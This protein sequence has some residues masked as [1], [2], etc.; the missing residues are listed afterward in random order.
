[1]RV[2]DVLHGIRRGSNWCQ[3]KPKIL[4]AV[5]SYHHFTP[6]STLT[7]AITAIPSQGHYSRAQRSGILG[8]KVLEFKECIT[9]RHDARISWSE[10]Y[11]YVIK[12]RTNVTLNRQNKIILRPNQTTTRLEST[13]IQTWPESWLPIRCGKPTVTLSL[14]RLEDNQ[15]TPWKNMKV[16]RTY[17]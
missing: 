17:W 7:L 9:I 2:Y 3:V 15:Y 12:S 8:D 4:P 1:M 10:S 13:W 5:Q 11:L 16:S 6:I 14:L